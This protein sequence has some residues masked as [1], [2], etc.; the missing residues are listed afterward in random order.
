MLFREGNIWHEYYLVMLYSN[1]SYPYFDIYVL[2]FVMDGIG[3]R[4]FCWK[5]EFLFTKARRSWQLLSTCFSAFFGMPTYF[6]LLSNCLG[7]APKIWTSLPGKR[8][9]G[10][11]Q[12]VKYFS[13]LKGVLQ[14]TKSSIHEKREKRWELTFST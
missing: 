11:G 2:V 8:K 13:K 9:K 7:T 10:Q 1:V 3:V 12:S 14:V 4:P 6:C 5:V